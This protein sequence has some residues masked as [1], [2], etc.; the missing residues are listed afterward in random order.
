MPKKDNHLLKQVEEST[1]VTM[2]ALGFAFLLF[3]MSF[4]PGEKE[5]FEQMGIA[6][7]ASGM[8]V[9]LLVH[10]LLLWPIE[11]KGRWV[12]WVKYAITLVGIIVMVT[13]FIS[14]VLS[15]FIDYP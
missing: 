2:I 8:G 15:F 1:I 11:Q 4:L 12:K 3:G 10:S 6:L 5:Y 9:I 7:G 13:G 14:Y